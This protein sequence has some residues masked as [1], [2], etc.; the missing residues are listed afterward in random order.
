[1]PAAGPSAAIQPWLLYPVFGALAVV[2]IGGGYETLRSSTDAAFARVAGSR[3]VDVGGHRLHIRCTGSGSPTVVLE[4]GLGGSSFAAW[5]LV[6]PEVSTFTRVCS[7]DR[8]GM[9]YSDP[10]PSPRTARRI[11]HELAQLLDHGDIRGPLVLVGASIGGL[12]V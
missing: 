1:M 2:A 9:G 12:Y 7:Y 4:N 3:L 10:G 5:S 11:A 8:A 6:Q